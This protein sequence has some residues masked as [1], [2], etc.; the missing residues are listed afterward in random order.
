VSAD[1]L[2]RPAAFLLAAVACVLALDVLVILYTGGYSVDLRIHGYG[3]RIAGHAI[4][5]PIILL[6]AV[7]ILRLLLR[8][9]A[10]A[11][12]AA[13]LLF[14]VI[15]IVYLA[16]GRAIPADDT[17]AARYLPLSILREGNF[18][19]DEFPFL[20]EHA[21]IESVGGHYVSPYPVGAALLA[22]PMYLPA[23]LGHVDAQS[24]LIAEL[25]KLSAAIAVALSAVVLYLAL[26]RLT[27]ATHALVITLVYAFGTS[28]LSTTSQAL[29]QHGASQLA[30]TVALYGLVRGRDDRWGALAGFALAFAV[31]SR[32][33]DAL[34]AVPLGLYVLVHR[35][36]QVMSFALAACLPILFQL[37][38]NAA[39]FANPFRLQFFPTLSAA[40]RQLSRGRGLWR[41]PF[42]DGFAGILVSPGRGLFI[43]SP[44]FL[45][46]VVGLALAWKKGGDL[47][48]RYASVGVL[49]TILL[50]SKWFSWWGGYTYGPRMLADLAPVLA[51]S[52]YPVLPLLHTSRALKAGFVVLA[53]WSVV[54]HSIGAFVDDR[55]W[56]ERVDVDNAPERLR[57]WTDNQLV[58]P[59]RRV[60]NIGH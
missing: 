54:A 51:M 10:P 38:Y 2:S 32:P 41:T 42:L 21:F 34:L 49:L 25:E 58:D 39:C 26:R 33:T 16:N 4:T 27:S 3:L 29:W 40:V 19:L 17:L 44:I 28:G 11:S 15:L 31:I 35:R 56:N 1:R 23:A 36:K 53:L 9:R 5:V 13:G 55:S 30:L 14:A 47:L 60:S 45:L 46:S 12:H 37:W 57:S 50:Y 43:Y 48:L 8:P 20:H 7:A 59:I 52:L 22:L 6:L 18:D 24:P